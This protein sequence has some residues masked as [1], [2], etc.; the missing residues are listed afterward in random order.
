[1]TRKALLCGCMLSPPLEKTRR[2]LR[3]PGVDLIEWR[4]DH[5]LGQH[6]LDATLE[7]LDLLSSGPRHPVIVT[8]RPVR[9]GGVYS[10]PEEARLDLLHWAARAGAEWVD[11]EADVSKDQIEEFKRLPSRLILSRHNFH[12]TP[13]TPV[14]RRHV[15][16][17][18]KAGA[19]VVKITTFAKTH[20]DNLRVLD[21]IPFGR[22]EFGVD[23][24][25][26]CMGPTG[27]WSRAVALLLDSPWAYVQLPG[28]E[29]SA[30]GQ[31][32]PDELRRLVEE[33]G[34]GRRE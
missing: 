15:T 20:E 28:Q 26:F 14:L 4:L 34:G 1:M 16:D 7:A 30:P 11:L 21:L 13:E 17:M 8:N 29:S 12:E 6:S 25:A 31:F 2:C 18:A 19:L 33:L 10:G 9:E 27:R 3:H 5:Y 23:V 22:K 24:L 32:L